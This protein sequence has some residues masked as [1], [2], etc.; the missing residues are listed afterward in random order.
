MTESEF[1]DWLSGIAKD[2][3]EGKGT[4]ALVHLNENNCQIAACGSE[5]EEAMLTLMATAAAMQ[6]T[7]T[8]RVLN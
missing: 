2:L 7:D 4:I 8:D 5:V 6:Q 3:K 1:S